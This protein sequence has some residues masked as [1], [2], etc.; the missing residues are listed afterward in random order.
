M[1][2]VM[3]RLFQEKGLVDDVGS[4]NTAGRAQGVTRRL[5]YHPTNFVI[6]E[7]RTSHYLVPPMTNDVSE[8]YLPHH[9]PIS[10]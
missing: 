2:Q 1:M 7:V 3:M 9:A 10:S 5:I 6:P 8:I 4:V